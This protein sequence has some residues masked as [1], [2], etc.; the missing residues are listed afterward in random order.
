VGVYVNLI[1]DD[2]FYWYLGGFEP[3]CS[4]LGLGKLSIAYGIRWSIATGRRYFDMTRGEESFKYYFG[5]ANR[6]CPS[7][8]VG[9]DRL[10]SRSAYAASDARDRLG[11]MARRARDL[12]Q[13]HGPG[14]SGIVLRERRGRGTVAAR[15]EVAHEPPDPAGVPPQVADAVAQRSVPVRDV[16]ART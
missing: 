14:Q 7:V 5:A 4:R 15:G 1:D 3:K 11:R 16:H 10:R 2:V 6:H 13:D 12:I 8:V 9:N